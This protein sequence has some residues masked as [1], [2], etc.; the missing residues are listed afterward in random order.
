[1]KKDQMKILQLLCFPLYGSGSGTYVR[2][3]S[4]ALVAD[5]EKV[6]IV[7]PDNRGLN[8]I[9]LYSVDLPFMAAF[10]GHPEYPGAKLYSKLTGE[11]LNDVQSAFEKAIIKAVEDFQ[12]DVIHV[13]HASNLS[14]VANYIKAVYQIHYIITS[15]NTDIIN[16][17]LDKRYIPLTQDALNR[18][19]IV[20]A[21]SNNTRDRLLDILGKGN[22]KLK[23]KVRVVPCGVDTKLFPAVGSV[24]NVN[25]EYKLENKKVVLYSGKVTS[26]KGVDFFVKAADKIPAAFFIVMGDGE[27]L[28]KMKKLAKD[29]K[30][31]NIIFTGYLGSDKKNLISG[32]YRRADVVAVPS[33]VSEG[34]PLS[35][36]EAM[37]AGSVVVASNIGG[38]PTPVKNNRNGI[39]VRP[40]SLSSLVEGIKLVLG[41]EKLSARLAKKARLDAVKIYDWKV[42]ANK[43]QRYY[44]TSYKRSEKNRATKKPSY[45]S[46]E[47]YFESKEFAQKKQKL[48]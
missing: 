44:L 17:I 28:D 46:E 5:G 37:S 10:T 12:P 19:D 20:T 41:N 30:L 4:E 29:L 6:A 16:A 1:M 39:L 45:I 31:K 9:K 14:W 34:I 40:R 21:V 2:K 8:N 38:I 42:I 22:K 13:H 26:I 35:V 11:E 32:L 3:L 25:R 33:T 23:N 36:L 18:A 43:M 48:F 15:H 47:E 27:E 7:A 24:E